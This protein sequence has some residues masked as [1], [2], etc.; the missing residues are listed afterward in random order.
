[1]EKFVS[2]FTYTLELFYKK[3]MS[4]SWHWVIFL[5]VVLFMILW[6]RKKYPAG[7]FVWYPLL[8]LAVIICPFWGWFLEKV[9]NYSEYYVRLYTIMPWILFIAVGLTILITKFGHAWARLL[10]LGVVIALLVVTGNFVY[11]KPQNGTVGYLG[12]KPTY[13]LVQ[14]ENWW[15][16]PTD[17]MDAAYLILQDAPDGARVL[18]K[19]QI[20]AYLRQYS[21]KFELTESAA[22]TYRRD[23][24][25][26]AKLL[27][28]NHPDVAVLT[29][30]CVQT[31][32]DYLVF[33]N[34]SEE[35]EAEFVNAGWEVLAYTSSGKYVIYRWA[36]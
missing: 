23:W 10:S 30:L 21:S 35:L 1:M 2:Y 4:T 28:T 11:A 15:K 25:D 14:R 36:E 6:G 17:A 8:A 12:G 20:G 16:I 3:Y 7:H 18:A 5:A 27:R 29:D 26:Y 13:R 24:S 34:V 19:Y 32:T 31:D 33:K 9:P 22:Y